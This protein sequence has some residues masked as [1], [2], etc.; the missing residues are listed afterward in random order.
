MMILYVLSVQLAT[1]TNLALL[2]WPS[3]F[4]GCVSLSKIC[5]SAESRRCI[6]LAMASR[7]TSYS[8]PITLME[9]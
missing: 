9:L 3:Y 1:E 8:K 5:S 4:R 2:V 6:N 7:H